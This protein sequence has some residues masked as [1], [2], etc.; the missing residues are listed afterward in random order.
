MIN[1]IKTFT[2][3]ISFMLLPLLVHSD[4]C[5]GS[6]S[7]A[8]FNDLVIPE[9]A[10][11]TLVSSVVNGN[12]EVRKNAMLEFDGQVEVFGNISATQPNSFIS[13]LNVIGANKIHGNLSIEGVGDSFF[14]VVICGSQFDKNVSI[15]GVTTWLA[16]G[17]PNCA[18]GGE[19]NTIGKNLDIS[20]NL[21]LTTFVIAQNNIGKNASIDNNLGPANKTVNNNQVGKNLSC[22]SNQSPFAASGNTAQ[23]L[24]GQ[25]A[26]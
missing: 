25:C 5:T 10:S 20:D 22:S 1:S 2:L 26:P 7:G 8:T 9:G 18:A 12:I 4:E 16:L 21:N 11:C 3:I 6:F 23:H 24:S 13:Q 19:G 14:A 17:G 15:S